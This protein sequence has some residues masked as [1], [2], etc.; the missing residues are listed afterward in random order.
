M[1]TNNQ[2]PTFIS[3]TRLSELNSGETLSALFGKLK[4]AVKS[5]I[6]HVNNANNPH[7]V[8]KQQIGL[9]NVENKA[10]IDQTP[11]FTEATALASIN[12]GEKMSVILGKIKRLF[13]S[14]NNRVVNFIGKTV[15]VSDWKELTIDDYPYFMRISSLLVLQKDIHHTSSSTYWTAHLDSFWML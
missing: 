5:L 12:S 8:T 1:K 2:Q 11:T 3:A 9:D 4:T 6:D 10:F 14:Y 7:K 13:T 15:A